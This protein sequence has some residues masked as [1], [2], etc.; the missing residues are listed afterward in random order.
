MLL[1]STAACAQRSFYATDA[2]T[3]QLSARAPSFG[4]TVIPDQMAPSIRLYIDNPEQ[5][6]VE[7]Q[8]RHKENGMVVDTVI[9]S[10]K[11]SQR[12][13]FEQADDG[14]YLVTLSCGKDR[15]YKNVQI[16]TITRRNAVV[17]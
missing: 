9:S 14:S 4:I 12:Y 16:N 17:E 2:N 11:F 7:L 8:I 10:H 15:I 13:N 5:K 3:K 6:K 1:M